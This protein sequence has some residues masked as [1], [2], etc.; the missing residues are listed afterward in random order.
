MGCFQSQQLN[1]ISCFRHHCTAYFRFIY[2]WKSSPRSSDLT[3]AQH[4]YVRFFRIPPPHFIQAF[5]GE[6]PFFFPLSLTVIATLWGVM[7]HH[8]RCMWVERLSFSIFFAVSLF[9]PQS[10]DWSRKTFPSSPQLCSLS[11]GEFFFIL[12]LPFVSAL[13][14]STFPLPLLCHA[15][16]FP[17]QVD[18]LSAGSMNRQGWSCDPLTSLTLP[19]S[20]VLPNLSRIHKEK[21]QNTW[22]DILCDILTAVFMFAS[23]DLH[24]FFSF[25]KKRMKK[26]WNSQINNYQQLCSS[27][28]FPA[29]R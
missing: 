5:Q 2:T 26:P 13:S 11:T 17:R 4:A 29:S 6:I 8:S 27:P 28:T 22:I 7:C 25:W 1:F 15:C 3:Y 12:Q 20:L 10:F 16:C 23:G 19:L 14:P 18:L 24:I 9:Y 21:S